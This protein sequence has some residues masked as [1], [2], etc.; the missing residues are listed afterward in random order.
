MKL[1]LLPVFFCSMWFVASASLAEDAETP[2]TVMTQPDSLLFSDDFSTDVLSEGPWRQTWSGS[3]VADGE[4]VASQAP[5]ADHGA[6]LERLVDFR[7]VVIQFS[8]QFD[9]STRFNVPIDDKKYKE[10]HAG[11]ICR[12]SITPKSI[13]LGDDREGVM[14]NDIFAM[15]RSGDPADKTKS[16]ELLKGRNVTVPADLKKGTWYTITL[17]ILGDEMLVSLDDEPIGYLQSPGIAHETKTDFGFTVVGSSVRFDNISAWS[18]KAASPDW[19]E[20]RSEILTAI[21]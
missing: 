10:S 19:D 16:D 8:F 14:R 17:E 7:D 6:V 21:R 13:L 15:R 2:A 12:L 1:L 9:G 4:L 11:H 20:K 3:K 18:V 5:D